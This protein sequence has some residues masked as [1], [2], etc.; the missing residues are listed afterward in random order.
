MIDLIFTHHT[1]AYSTSQL[2]A[3]P[4]Q[5]Y[6][7]EIISVLT[8]CVCFRSP[9]TCGRGSGELDGECRSS[10]IL[11]FLHLQTVHTEFLIRRES[12]LLGRLCL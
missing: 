5:L 3:E 2:K 10:G 7:I 6:C 9:G 12:R 4:L 11:L 1:A 8:S